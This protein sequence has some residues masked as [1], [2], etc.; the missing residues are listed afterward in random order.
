LVRRGPCILAPSGA[1]GKAGFNAPGPPGPDSRGID[2]PSPAS[3]P[4]SRDRP[5]GFAAVQGRH[6]LAGLAGLQRSTFRALARKADFSLG[7]LQPRHQAPPFLAADTPA[8]RG[9]SHIKRAH[10]E[11]PATA[12]FRSGKAKPALPQGLWPPVSPANS[13]PGWLSS[14]Q[15][16]NSVT[17]SGTVMGTRIWSWLA[18]L[19]H[20]AGS[21]PTD[22]GTCHLG[23][24]LRA[25]E[26]PIAPPGLAAERRMSPPQ[27]STRRGRRGPQGK[28]NRP[29]VPKDLGGRHLWWG[30]A[31]GPERQRGSPTQAPAKPDRLQARGAEAS[32]YLLKAHNRQTRP[33]EFLL[34]K[35]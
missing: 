32:F 1:F 17:D 29:G 5:E 4:A 21:A 8:E 2:A 30:S 18:E 28:P 31:A 22:H 27:A 25:C 13:G 11:A 26:S 9:G 3:G 7:R 24:L 6:T 35:Q 14:P 34:C 20:A 12:S 19:D 10:F 23:K 33:E 16:L 15:P